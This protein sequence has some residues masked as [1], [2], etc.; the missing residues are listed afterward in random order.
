MITSVP[1]EKGENDM[2][3]IK[4]IIRRI[5]IN[6]ICKLNRYYCPDCIYHEWD[7]EGVIFRGNKCRLE[8]K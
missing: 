7:F 3:V 1:T 6:R 2:G 8:R 4:Q 5:K